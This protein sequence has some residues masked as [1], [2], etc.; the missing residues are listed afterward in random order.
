MN[1]SLAEAFLKAQASINH[2]QKDATNPHF[3]NHYATLESVI[4]AVK[5]SLNKNGLGFFQSTGK[6]SEGHFVDT[7]IYSAE[8]DSALTSRTYLVLGKN[9]MQGLGSAIT[10]ARRYALAALCG[11]TQADD[12]GESASF[13]QAPAPYRAPPSKPVKAVSSVQVSNQSQSIQPK[14]AAPKVA[15]APIDDIPMSEEWV[16]PYVAT[17]GPFKGRTLGDAGAEAVAKQLDVVNE[18][19][20]TRKAQPN[21]EVAEFINNAKAFLENWSAK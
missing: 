13:N 20:R 17:F 4:D 18:A 9:D 19:L 14:I 8:S 12:D 21:E 15:T 1:K 10:Y 5:P 7:V 16:E 3:K 11:I 2:A 6:D